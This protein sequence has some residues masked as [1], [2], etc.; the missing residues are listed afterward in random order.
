[1][2]APVTSD[3]VTGTGN[4]AGWSWTIPASPVYFGLTFYQQALV[5]DP[6]VNALGATVSNSCAGWIGF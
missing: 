3:L 5:L 6:G 2:V 4:V 1:M